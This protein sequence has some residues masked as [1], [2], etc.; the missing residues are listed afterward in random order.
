MRLKEDTIEFKILISVFA[1]CVNILKLISAESDSTQF[2]NCVVFYENKGQFHD[3]NNFAVNQLKFST[4]LNGN[5]INFFEDGFSYQLSKV[6]SWKESIVNTKSDRK[7]KVPNVYEKYRVDFRWINSNKEVKI[8]G[9]SVSKDYTN[10]YLPSCPSGAINVKTYSKLGYKSV[11]HGIDAVWYANDFGVKYDYYVSAGANYKE[12]QLQVSGAESIEITKVGDLLI[13][14]PLGD[15]LEGAPLVKQGNRILTSS[16]ILK[17]NI[18]SFQIDGVNPN[19]SFIIDPVVRVWGTYYL[20]GTMLD[21]V[22]NLQGELYTVG[23]SNSS[24]LIATTGAF[25]TTLVGTSAAVITKFNTN[26]IRLWGTYY[27]GNKDA[28]STACTIDNLG[29]LYVCGITTSDIS[30]PTSFGAHQP[31]Y[32]GGT[33]DGFIL[34]FNSS[35]MRIFG[36]LYGGNNYDETTKCSVNKL[37]HLVIS[38]LTLS[39]NGTSIATNGSHQAS[40]VANTNNHDAFI[41]KFDSTGLRL[42]G[43]YY[44]GT[45]NDIGYGVAIDSLDNAYLV[46]ETNTPTG[47]EFFTTSAHQN[48]FAGSHDGFIAKFDANGQRL[49]GTYY[50]GTSDDG[51][52]DVLVDK[53]NHVFISGYAYSGSNIASPGTF[54]DT[55]ALGIGAILI[56]FNSNGSRIWG[57]YFAQGMTSKFVSTDIYGNLYIGGEGKMF[58]NYSTPGV[59]QSVFGGGNNDAYI[60]KFSNHGILRW[61]TY[62]GG[63][64]DDF[65]YACSA[66]T[67]MNVFFIG[68]SFSINDTAISTPGSLFQFPLSNPGYPSDF[69]VKLKDTDDKYL[70]L[71][72]SVYLNDNVIIY[73]NPSEGEYNYELKKDQNAVFKLYDQT[74]KLINEQ[75]LNEPYGKLDLY[76]VN[77]GIYFLQM[78]DKENGRVIFKTKLIRR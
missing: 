45:G 78:F 35:G 1:I 72:E 60:A 20:P 24:S 44:G 64:N 34:K 74:G 53:F 3:Q 8:I 22:T 47:S 61:S 19:E 58:P 6:K 68:S 36:T 76:S 51:F 26:G 25:Q 67:S 10:Y 30:F 27:G 42:W 18:V 62:Y 73:P 71:L 4:S 29:D 63:N 2:M 77:P 15:I 21:C 28:S 48:Y 69:M 56:K 70:N 52:Y 23:G 57:T 5:E 46:G 55:P 65:G 75:V 38:G 50:G 49:W 66:D 31:N 33:T 54:Q 12:I 32:G 59:H 11:Y 7:Y 14:T 17:G 37:G 9:E 40:F 41:V 16:W 43:S 13:H 39:N